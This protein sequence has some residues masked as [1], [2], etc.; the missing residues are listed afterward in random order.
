MHTQPQPDESQEKLNFKLVASKIR[1][2]L[3]SPVGLQV[4]RKDTGAYF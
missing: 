3:P 2:R 4:K 1:H